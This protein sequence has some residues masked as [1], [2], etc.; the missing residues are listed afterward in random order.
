MFV[1]HLVA[2][3]LDDHYECDLDPLPGRKDARQHPIHGGRVSKPENYLIDEPSLADG[4]RHKNNLA[5]KRNLK[6][7]V[8]GIKPVHLLLAAAADHHR[9]LVNERVRYHG[10]HSFV[11]AVSLELCAQMFVPDIVQFLL[12]SC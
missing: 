1:H 4:P 11:G 7:A 8:F 9:N 5:I 6:Q 2:V 3:K 12:I 10:G